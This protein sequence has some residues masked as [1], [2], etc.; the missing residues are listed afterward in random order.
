MH[1]HISH[2]FVRAEPRERAR[3]YLRGILDPVGRRN[4]WQLAA[5]VGEEHPDGMQRLLSTARWNADRV[6]DDVRDF[7]LGYAGDRNAVLVVDEWRF[8]KKGRRSVGVHLARS[9]GSRRTENVQTG[10][11]CTYVAQRG[12]YLIDRELFLPATWIGDTGL[13]RSARIPDGLPYRTVAELAGGMVTRAI[14]AQVPARWVAADVSVIDLPLRRFLERNPMWFLIGVRTDERL[15]MVVGD[16]RGRHSAET[17]A[18]LLDGDAW[19]TRGASQVRQWSAHEWARVRLPV[20]RPGSGVRWLLLRRDPGT[21]ENLHAYLCQAGPATTLPDLVEIALLLQRNRYVLASACTGAG[22]DEYEVRHWVGW[23]RY[24]TLAL[25]AHNCLAL[26]GSRNDT[27]ET[28]SIPA[29]RDPQARSRLPR[30]EPRTDTEEEPCPTPVRPSTRSVPC[31][32]RCA[33][34]SNSARSTVPARRGRSPW[35]VFPS[36]RSRGWAR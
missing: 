1:G 9:S 26:A 10:L 13:R 16:H 22:L 12:S 36:G 8:A 19:A 17:V 11:F 18:A 3:T 29:A 6:R 30:P 35:L 34:T 15:P 25:A 2:R 31:A 7:V 32:T 28:V 20:A 21:G 23:Y 4:G 33:S 5:R 14:A 27:A 24:T